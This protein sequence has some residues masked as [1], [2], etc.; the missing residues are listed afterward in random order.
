MSCKRNKEL[1]EA[2]N[3]NYSLN[4][5]DQTLDS[6]SLNY[7]ED[8]NKE[9]LEKKRRGRPPKNPTPAKTTGLVEESNKGIT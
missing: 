9:G 3:V 5:S 7:V 8:K 1:N 6:S 2:H 4:Q